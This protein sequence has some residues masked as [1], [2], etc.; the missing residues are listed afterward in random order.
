MTTRNRRD[1]VRWILGN[2]A[3]YLVQ[4]APIPVLLVRHRA[5]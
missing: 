4:R 3:D 1:P 2:I 5:A